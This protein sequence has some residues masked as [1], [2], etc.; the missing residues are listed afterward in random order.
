MADFRAVQVGDRVVR[1][2]AGE[3]PMELLVTEV[4]D[5]LIV[6]GGAAGWTFDRVTGIEIDEELGWGPQFG[7]TGSYLVLAEGGDLPRDPELLRYPSG[8]LD[9]A[10]GHG[11]AQ[12]HAGH[13]SRE[14]AAAGVEPGWRGLIQRLYDVIELARARGEEVAVTQ[15][16]Q[17]W[18]ELRIYLAGAAAPAVRP[19]VEQLRAA[20]RRT[21]EGCGAPAPGGPRDVLRGLASLPRVR[22][23]CDDCFAAARV[24]EPRRTLGRV[25]ELLRRIDRERERPQ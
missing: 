9:R 20:S 1:L 25:E 2:L 8:C 6:C 11:P 5:D 10:A 16:K 3:L 7:I 4:T 18:G 21:C 12:A 23:Y 14:C 15:V 19:L 22:A 17:K 24:G 13:T